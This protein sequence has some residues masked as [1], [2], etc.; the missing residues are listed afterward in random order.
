MA[1]IAKTRAS[2][3][4][5]ALQSETEAIVSAIDDKPQAMLDAYLESLVV[6]R[7]ASE[8]TI[9]GY[10]TDLEAF[11]RWCTRKGV[12]PFSATHRQLR[13]YLGEMDTARYARSTINRRLSSIRGFYRWMNLVGEMDA[14]PAEALSG[15]KQGRHLPHVLKADEMNRLLSVHD[16]QAADGESANPS[17]DEQRDRALLEFLYASGAR[18]SEAAMLKVQDI[19]LESKQVKL[20]G[21]GRKERIVPLHGICVAAMKEYLEGGRS[22]LLEGKPPTDRVFVSSRGKPMG[23]DSLRKR[24]K[25]AVNAAGLD[26]SL[27]PHDMRHTFATDLLDGHADLRSV[28]EMLGHASLSTTQVYTHLSP[29]RLKEAHNQAHPRSNI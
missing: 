4:E 21:K 16:G 18:I 17:P 19:D 8:H 14:N 20:F 10:R 27:S 7:A 3:K 15:P 9:R 25:S 23:P 24:Y 11:L 2:R 5:L 12:D 22:K 1:R 13:A 28:Q 26:A 6:E 29:A